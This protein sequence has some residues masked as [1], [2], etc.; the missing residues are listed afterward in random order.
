MLHTVKV[1]QYTLIM[2][3]ACNESEVFNN[4]IMINKTLTGEC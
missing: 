1:E 2:Y 3:A 4:K